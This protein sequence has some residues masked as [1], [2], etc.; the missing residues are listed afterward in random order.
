MN[1]H[2]RQ[3]LDALAHDVQALLEEVRDYESDT[4]SASDASLTPEEIVDI[5]IGLAGGALR[6]FTADHLDGVKISYELDVIREDDTDDER[7]M[8]A[9]AQE[10]AL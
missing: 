9:R 8:G 6:S 7:G 10:A 1:E 2:V 5:T 4:F 3:V